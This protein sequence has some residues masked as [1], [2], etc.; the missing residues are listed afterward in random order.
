M[1]RKEKGNMKAVPVKKYQLND[2]A[3]MNENWFRRSFIVY[4]FAV[5]VIGLSAGVAYV[6]V[7]AAAILFAT[8]IMGALLSGIKRWNISNTKTKITEGK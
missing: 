2:L 1:T 4:S 6:S 5:F 7:E 8:G 3:D